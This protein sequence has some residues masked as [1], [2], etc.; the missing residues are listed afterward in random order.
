[1]NAYKSSRDT[2]LAYAYPIL[3]VM[4]PILLYFVVV[5]GVWNGVVSDFD[6]TRGAVMKDH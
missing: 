5:P 1:M 3:W 4:V 6:A 2:E